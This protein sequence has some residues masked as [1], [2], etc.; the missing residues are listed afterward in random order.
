MV[1]KIPALGA[2]QFGLAYGVANQEGQ[3]SRPTAKAM[4]NSLLSNSVICVA[5]EDHRF[6]VAE[7]LEAANIV[8][9]TG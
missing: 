7:I 2:V 4:L 5:S 9:S 3:V 6:L 8:P 1:K